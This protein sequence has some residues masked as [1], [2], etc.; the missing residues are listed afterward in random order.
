MLKR[1]SLLLVT[2]LFGVTTIF[3]A[4]KALKNTQPMIKLYA[5]PANSSKVIATV[6]LY[7]QM[8]SIIHKGRWAKVG[9]R[10]DGRV[11][12]I[13]LDKYEQ[14]R[15]AILQPNIQTVYIST[16]QDDKGKPTV[17]V[18]AYHNGKRLSDKQAKVFY[19]KM[20]KQQR[21][22]QRAQRNYWRH[23]NHMMRFQQ[24]EM[25]EMMRD[26]MFMGNDQPIILMPGPVLMPPVKHTN[27]QAP[28]ASKA[29]K[30]SH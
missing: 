21:Q 4:T 8:V 19:E 9:L 28:A 3:A 1:I 22:E 27:K 26:D 25:D 23:F 16:T 17:N 7:T 24:H 20:V 18:V 14:A 2:L 5:A 11:G 13:N 15:D 30:A 10:T 6:P 12:W 29:P